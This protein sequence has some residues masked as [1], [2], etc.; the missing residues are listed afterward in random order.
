MMEITAPGSKGRKREIRAAAGERAPVVRRAFS[1]VPM[2]YRFSARAAEPGRNLSGRV[3]VRKSRWIFPSPPATLPLL[4]ENV[5]HA[6]FWTTFLAVEVVADVDVVLRVDEKRLA[7]GGM[8][9][10]LLAAGILAVAVA[11]MLIGA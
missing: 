10:L 1:S 11:L 7:R 3:L 9:I 2:D 4:A 8:S 5:V 6:G